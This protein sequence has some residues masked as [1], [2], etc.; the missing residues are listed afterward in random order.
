MIEPIQP[1][2]QTTLMPVDTYPGQKLERS[3]EIPRPV[4]ERKDELPTAREEIPRE[5]VEQ[6]ADKLSRMM[7][8]IDKRLRFELEG[9]SEPVWVRVVDQDTEEVL[10]RLRPKRIIDLLRY[11]TDIAGL[12]VDEKV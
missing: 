4:V 1:N 12:V 5:Q 6:A 11:I 8:L 9:D 3:Q 10:S 2:K 7:S